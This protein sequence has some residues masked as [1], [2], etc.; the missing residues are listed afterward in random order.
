MSIYTRQYPAS[1]WWK[2][3]AMMQDPEIAPFLPETE[4]LSYSTLQSFLGDY[5]V[6]FVKPSL[7]GG[8]VGILKITKLD[9]NLGY[10]LQ[11]AHDVFVFPDVEALY[12]YI[13][14]IKPPRKR[15]LVQQGLPLMMLDKRPVDFRVLLLRTSLKKG[16]KCYGIMGK[17][18]AENKVVTNKSQGG[19]SVRLGD[20]LKNGLEF[21]EKQY[22]EMEQQMFQLGQQVGVC[23]QERFPYVNQLGLDLG[24]DRDGK[25]WL[26]EANT[27]P[28]YQLFRD[29][30]KPQ[31]YPLIQKT[32]RR[33][34][35]RKRVK[36]ASTP[37]LH[38][39]KPK[40]VKK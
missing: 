1:K 24:I 4:D 16:W 26:I 35:S 7:G 37:G 17:V 27:R 6:V 3:Q 30:E 20:A 10:L 25:L 11:G 9:D 8:G 15:Y 14:K 19:T 32:I 38:W 21:T 40:Q 33:L 18:A 22:Q 34:R 29:H 28:N 12:R 5:S 2:H 23:F 31:L 36:K 39:K 13:R